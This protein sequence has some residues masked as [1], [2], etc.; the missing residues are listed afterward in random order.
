D[1]GGTMLGR[2][3]RGAAVTFGATR[4]GWRETTL[5]G[6]IASSSLRN[7]SRDGF[8]VAVSLAAG[9]QV[10]TTPSDN[11]PV[12]ATAVA[13]ALFDRVEVR[14]GWVQVKRTAWIP[15]SAVGEPVTDEGQQQATVG[16]PPAA[17]QQDEGARRAASGA[18]TVM[19]A[20]AMQ[21]SDSARPVLA[22]GSEFSAT[23]AGDPIGR[24]EAALPIEV[25]ERRDG[26]SRVQIDVWVPDASLSQGVAVGPTGA[27][28]RADP[29]RY[30]GHTVEW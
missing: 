11:A 3:L 6:W 29:D 4:D 12:R 24:I 1:P 19:P 23:R 27:E 20:T 2:V 21:A 17:G 15:A 5:V 13:G 25:T 28:L 10:H 22:P 8:D 9:A 18:P 30:V 26:W 7:D 14:G 16:P